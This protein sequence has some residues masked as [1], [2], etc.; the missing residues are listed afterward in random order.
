MCGRYGYTNTDREKIKKRFRLKDICFD[1]V[2]R[3][4]MAP[5]QDVP[6]ILNAAPR[7]MQ[8]ARWGLVPFWAKDEKIG[9]KMINA[10]AET[11][12]EKPAYRNA[13]KKKRCLVPADFFF[14]WQ[15]TTEGKQPHCIRLKSHDSFSFAGIWE[16]WREELISCSIITCAANKDVAPVHG[17]M[18]VILEE[19]DEPQWLD[20]K[21]IESFLQPLI[22]GRIEAYPISTLVNFPK[23][24]GPDILQKVDGNAR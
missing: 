20:G 10:R 3:Y 14:E 16:C 24:D 19:Q 8:L 18:P 11:I 6:V 23:N 13:I 22:D 1:P 12:F 17:R 2:P 15:K 7:E 4:N 9:Y 21:Q 5:G